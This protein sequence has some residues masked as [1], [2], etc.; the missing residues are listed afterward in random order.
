MRT[1]GTLWFY[2]PVSVKARQTGVRYEV[3]NVQ[4]AAENL[5]EWP[6][7][8]PHWNKAVQA[9]LAALAGELSPDDVRTAFEAA[10]RKEGLLLD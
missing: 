7:R 4:A 2:P 9:C 5:L 1:H 6:K 8:G 3:N 10:A